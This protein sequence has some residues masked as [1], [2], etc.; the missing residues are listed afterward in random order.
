MGRN[1][2]LALKI[3]KWC[4]S[5]DPQHYARAQQLGGQVLERRT[6]ETVIKHRTSFPMMVTAALGREFDLSEQ[7]FILFINRPATIHLDRLPRR[8]L[9]S[10]SQLMPGKLRCC[11]P[12]LPSSH[13]V[14]NPNATAES[15]VALK[16]A[17]YIHYPPWSSERG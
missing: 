1:L 3:H 6:Q 13:K 2:T 17:V 16:G 12:L 5:P 4:N 7:E 15:G 10:I 8:V 11:C 9:I 14:F